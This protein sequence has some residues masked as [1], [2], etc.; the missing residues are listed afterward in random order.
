MAKTNKRI[1]GREEECRRLERCMDAD[2]AQLVIV[3]G[4]RRVGKT[5]LINQ[6]FNNKFAYKITGVYGESRAVQLKNF[7]TALNRNSR[8]KYAVPNDWYEAFEYLREYIGKLSKKSKQVFFFDE[9]P[10]LDTHKSGFLSAFEWFWNDYASTMDNVVFIVCGSATAWMDKKIVKNKGGLFHRQTCKLYLEPF[11]LATVEQYLMERNIRW[12]RYDIVECYMVMGGIPYYLSLLDEA[13][14]LKQNIDNLFFKNKGELWDEFEHLYKTLFS[15]SEK[16]EAVVEALST[17]KYGMTRDEIISKTGICSGGD[18]STILNNL[19]LS[20]F[21]RATGFYEKKKKEAVYQLADYYTLFYFKYIRNNYGKDE[22]YWMNATENPTR[23][24]WSGY[25][26]EQVCMD[27]ISQIKYKLQIGGVLSKEYAWSI[28]A[29]EEKGITGA[30]IDLLIDRRDHVVSICEMKYSVN[31]FGIDKGYDEDL[32]NKIDSFVRAT[33]CK[34]TVQ[35]VMV[36]TYGLKPSKY[37]GLVNAEVE[38]DD[39]FYPV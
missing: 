21:V 15:N 38:L 27:H 20:G 34:K 22:H 4:R 33:D 29:D 17:K 10:W 6:F 36:T 19:I 28:S 7:I 2:S 12:S 37:N 35:L 24:T 16:Y 9:M 3:Y 11:D 32:R 5:F 39:L 31:K 25:A 1:L 8:K 18:L 23:R 13:L 30:Q 26:F 14:T